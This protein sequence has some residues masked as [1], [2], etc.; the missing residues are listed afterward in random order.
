MEPAPL[1][2]R[3]LEGLGDG[4]PELESFRAY[5]LAFEAGY[6]SD[7]WKTVDAHLTEDALW[8]VAGAPPPLGGVSQG[9]E[10]IL[11][12]IKESCDS[13]D[14]RFDIRDPRIVHG[15][16]RIPGGVHFTWVVT[17][18]RHGLPPFEL[19]GEEWDFFRDGKLEFH[20]E[21]FT[22]LPEAVEYLKSHSGSLL[23]AR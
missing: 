13:F 20:R 10:A 4:S 1:A 16:T 17:Y 6:A 22:N 5:A 12:A 2:S 9:R 11:R 23:P 8:V 15:P 21:R 7:D 14:R 3:R 18:R 19:H